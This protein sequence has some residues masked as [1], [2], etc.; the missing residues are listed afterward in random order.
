MAQTRRSGV[1]ELSDEC[2]HDRIEVSA[3]SGVPVLLQAFCTVPCAYLTEMALDINSGMSLS[4]AAFLSLSLIYST[5][6]PP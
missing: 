1:D 5:Q 2:L 6:H 3:P 4:P